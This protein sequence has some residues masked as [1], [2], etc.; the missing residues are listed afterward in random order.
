MV[1][2]GRR[3]NTIN[4]GEYDA[5]HRG[6][7]VQLIQ[8]VEKRENFPDAENIFRVLFRFDANRVGPPK[9]PREITWQ[10]ITEY[11]KGPIVQ[12]ASEPWIINEQMPKPSSR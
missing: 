7:T 10:L 6:L 5:V 4:P 12:F 1:Q 3:R 8:L 9:Y 2:S 11:L